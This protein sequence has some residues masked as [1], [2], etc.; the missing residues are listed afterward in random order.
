MNSAETTPSPCHF[1]WS[2]AIDLIDTRPADMTRWTLRRCVASVAAALV[3]AALSAGSSASSYSALSAREVNALLNGLYVGGRM[4][5]LAQTASQVNALLN[6]LYVGGRMNELAQTASQVIDENP[7]AVQDL[8]Y[9]SAFQFLGVAQYALGDLVEATRTFERAVRVNPDDVMSWIHLGDCYLFQLQLAKSASALE[10]AVVQKGARAQLHRLFKARNW[11]ADWRDR[12]DHLAEIE[13]ALVDAMVLGDDA[14]RTAAYPGGMNALDFVELP[15]P[16]L[17]VGFVSSDFGVHPV[18]TLL[19]GMLEMLSSPSRPRPTRVFCFALTNA[20]SWWKR[21][22]TRTV[23]RMVSLSGKD[24]REAA[25]VIRRHRDPREAAAVIR[26]HRVHVLIDLNGH[27]LHSGL[28]IFRHRPAPV[29]IAFLGYPMTTGD[30]AIDWIVTDAVS[31]PVETSDAFFTEKLLVL[32]T[33]YIV[34]DHLQMFGH[35]LQDARPTLVTLLQTPSPRTPLV[36][37]QLAFLKS[38][39]D[40][41]VRAA[42]LVLDTSLKNGHTTLLDALCAGVPVLTLE[43]TRMSNRAGSSMLHSLDL[44]AATTVHSFK[45]YVDV[46]VQLAT[47]MLDARRQRVDTT[48]DR[49]VLLRRLRE[50]LE[51]RRLSYPLF[52]T[53]R[54]TAR[55][56]STLE[57]ALGLATMGRK[58]RRLHAL[59]AVGKHEE[60]VSPRSFPVLSALHDDEDDEDEDEELTPTREDSDDESAGAADDDDDDDLDTAAVDSSEPTGAAVAPVLLH[61]GGQAAAKHPEWRIVDIQPGDHVDDVLPMDDLSPSYDDDSAPL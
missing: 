38:L 20:T 39:G 46:A 40:G 48:A 13:A 45:E 54:Y 37:R 43:G 15:A 29:Q 34:N 52:D 10:V 44:R 14:K 23:E 30:A 51:Q 41:V 8:R 36:T 31:T 22:I 17:R 28:P 9:P 11:M 6:G 12:D 58:T 27:T 50:T 3:A 18:A 16:L 55:F 42:D 4:N 60:V 7:R 32:P 21:N 56:H 5:E 47:T 35:T 57:T 1:D 59:V 24:P 61:I 49:R 53:E 19:R 26:R 25:A 33:H 2:A